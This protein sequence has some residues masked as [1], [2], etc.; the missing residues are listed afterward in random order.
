M[1]PSD[2]SPRTSHSPLHHT[3]SKT[4][5][6]IGASKQPPSPFLRETAITTSITTYYLDMTDPSQRRSS[7]KTEA[8]LIV[9][10]SKL[11]CPEL[12]RFLYTAVG[13]YWYWTDRLE[14][15]YQQWLDYLNRREVQTWIGYVQGTPAG[16]FELEKQRGDDVEIAYFGLLAQFI[17]KGLGGRLLTSAV[18]QA[19]AMGARRVWVHT[20]TLDG[21]TALSNYLARGFRLYKEVVNEANLADQTPGPWPGAGPEPHNP[22]SA[23]N[24]AGTI[25]P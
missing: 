15:T 17:G 16:Y 5:V 19:W 6:P 1:F 18:E 14:W 12:N 20:C 13:G 21:P 8:E 24:N 3:L 2:E 4:P 11:A 23:M 22:R 7:T 25:A 9:Q 10:Q